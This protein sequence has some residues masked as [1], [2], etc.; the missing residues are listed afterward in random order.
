MTDMDRQLS[1]SDNIRYVKGVGPKRALF[2]QD[3]GISTVQELLNHFPFR[4]QDFSQVVTLDKVR[5]GDEVTVMGRVFSVNFV[6]SLRGA[7]LRV[8]ITDG[9]GSIFLVWYNMPFMYR[10][11]RK[12]QYLLASGRVEWRRDSLEMAHPIWK[13]ATSGAFESPPEN[14]ATTRETLGLQGASFQGPGAN[15][16]IIPVYHGTSTLPSSKIQSIV[17]ETLRLYGGLI[18]DDIP[19]LVREK[20]GLLPVPKA[21]RELHIP[22]SSSSW[23]TARK[24]LAFREVLYL[25]IAL[26]LMKKENQDVRNA[27]VFRDFSL[28]D[29]FISSLPFSL[30]RGQEHAIKEIQKDLSSGRVMNRLLQGDVGSGK[31]VVAMWALFACAS[32]GYQGALLVPTEV[33][34]RQHMRTFQRLAPDLARIGFLSGSSSPKERKACLDGLVSGEVQILVGTHAI[35]EPVLQWQRLG[36][37]VT[38]EQHR[39]GVHQRLNLQERSLKKD[40]GREQDSLRPI[41]HVLVMS[42]TPIPRSLALTFYGDLD[43]TVIDS[44]PPGRKPVKTVVLDTARRQVAYKAVR[45]EVASGRQAY[46]VCPLI[47]EGKTGR[48]AVEGVYR[49]LSDEYLRGL[50]IG[51]IHGDMS[52]DSIDE[53]MSRF[54]RGET[55]VLV[56]TTVIEVGVDVENATCMVVEDADSFGLATLHQLRGRVGR[57]KDDS[58]CFLISSD[59]KN[60]RL[61][62]L[63]K[64][65]DGFSVAELD[66][67]QRGPGEFFGKRQH[68]VAE[69]DFE[70]LGLTVDTI[71]AARDAAAEVL[72]ALESSGAIESSLDSESIAGS[73]PNTK[74]LRDTRDE[75]EQLIKNVKSKFGN[76]FLKS[77]SR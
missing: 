14:E 71:L 34:A 66:L 23:E 70:D 63:E 17:Q 57:G 19:R 8:G 41:P 64:I 67:S 35:L 16:P 72:R 54:V 28:A 61:A 36:L 73:L 15:G 51:L 1:L 77:F 53:E 65:Q 37:I 44:M 50:K 9:R 3:L 46:I 24:T 18:E 32:N 69:I 22:G 58:Y 10:N 30:T 2:F 49:E 4:I 76:L 29:R 68:G 27:L 40:Q 38:D 39:F 52:K 31:T 47:K 33:L 11:F 48:K 74:T 13:P 55:Q 21:Y 59:G 7:A 56:S 42:A 20:Y 60:K 62:A 25:Q 75:Y 26:L 43:I 6:K 12:G 5:P 45:D